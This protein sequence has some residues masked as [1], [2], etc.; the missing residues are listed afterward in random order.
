MKADRGGTEILPALESVLTQKTVPE[1]ARQVVVLTDGEVSNT[2]AVLELAKAH[3]KTT[4]VFTIGIG[5]GASQNL[6]QGQRPTGVAREENNL[7]GD[8]LLQKVVTKRVCQ[9]ALT[10]T[11]VTINWGSL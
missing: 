3:A 10:L 4:R 6:L 9:K 11:A 8:D 2:D 5:A 1:L 7:P